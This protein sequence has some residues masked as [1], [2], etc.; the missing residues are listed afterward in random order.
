VD[1]S[2]PGWRIRQVNVKVALHLVQCF[3]GPRDSRVPQ[4]G[5]LPAATARAMRSFRMKAR[6]VMRFAA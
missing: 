3:H 2:A 6:P 1:T 4:S 5:H